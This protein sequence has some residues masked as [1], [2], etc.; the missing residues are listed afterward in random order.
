MPKAP[1]GLAVPDYKR[2]GIEGPYFG[3]AVWN[4]LKKL[5][6][7]DDFE[8][9]PIEVVP[10]PEGSEKV[11]VNESCRGRVVY[12]VHSTYVEPPRHVMIGAE[13]CDALVRADA[14]KVYFVELFNTYHRQDARSAREP[15][16]A[17]LVAE[18]YEAAGM[19][20]LFTAD[21]HS[22][23]L[24][25]FFRY[26][27]PL[28]MA[29]RLATHLKQNYQRELA[30][31]VVVAPDHGGY[32]RAEHFANLLGVP[33]AVMHKERDFS[34]TEVVVKDVLGNV[35]GKVVFL[36]DD[37]LSTGKTNIEAAK[38]L[39]E[40][41]AVK[42]YTVATH[43][44]LVRDARQRLR[45]A[46]IH[47]IGTNTVPHTFSEEEEEWFDVVDISDII[48]D[49]IYTESQRG[50]ISRFFPDKTEKTDDSRSPP[51]R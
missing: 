30:Q 22:K 14:E 42:I 28:P 45:D 46:D 34:G 36:R 17:R 6:R 16:T 1:F 40:R 31:A 47:V 18:L 35:D 49:V 33:I 13:M 32:T 43:L 50:S 15:I 8:Y 12:V 23:Q 21:P 37:I 26:M 7:S 51:K 25:G 4:R 3:D 48:A 19:S 2:L 44:G 5:D 20:G 9:I 10:F 41:G 29:N 11:A 39:R 27:E 38:A 24:A